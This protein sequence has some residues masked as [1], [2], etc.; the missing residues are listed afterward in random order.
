M[1]DDINGSTGLLLIEMEHSEDAIH[2]EWD[3]A[4]KYL[5]FVGAILIFIDL[6]QKVSLINKKGC[7][8]LGYEEEEI[9]GKNW[10]DSFIPEKGREGAKTVF[11]KLVTGETESVEY[12]EDATLTKSGEE[13][14]IS[15]HDTAVTDDSGNILGIFKS[16]EDITERSRA[17]EAIK[18]KEEKYRDVVENIK[19]GLYNMDLKGRVYFINPKIAEKIS[20]YEIDEIEGKSLN[21]LVP[22]EEASVAIKKL[23]KVLKGEVVHNYETKIKTKDGTVI[24]ILMSMTPKMKYGKVTGLFG[25]VNDISELKEAEKA[26]RESEKKYSAIVN[27]GSDGVII[28]KDLKV[29]FSNQKTLDLIGY[30]KI[31]DTR[32]LNLFKIVRHE[33]LLKAFDRY[34]R[35]MAGEEVPQTLEIE[36][37]H[38]D[39]H[40]IPA[41]LNSS[42]IE[43]NGGPADVI[44]LREITERKMADEKLKKTLKDLERSNRELEQ[45]AFVASHDLQ[46]PLRMVG[47]YVQLLS[48]RYSG[49]LGP[50]A[51]EFIEYAVDGATRMHNMINDLLTYSRVG[52]RGKTLEPTDC[53]TVLDNALLALLKIIEENN[54]VITHDP[55]PT[56]MADDDQLV[57][58]FQN[59]I[60]NAIRYRSE[61]PPSIHI[62]AEEKS[63][64]WLFSVR[65]NGIGIDPEYKDMIFQVFFRLRDREQYGTGMGLANCEKIVERHGGRMWVESKPGEGST[66]Y[67]TIPLK[68]V[69]N[70]E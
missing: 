8:I 13:R 1:M 47:S 65:D 12:F 67:F 42:K 39:G 29:V 6:N 68:G 60:D 38:K 11:Q 31:D 28:I 64:F 7:E 56:V 46:E 70:D 69:K 20:G 27:G 49:K 22:K 5:D 48:R 3:I 26:L 32:Q 51:D 16:G 23:Q 54:A 10:F 37:S 14:L 58:V 59:L 18:A 41:E 33:Y 40:V 55:L 63:D 30:P 66:F 17:E 36:L 21:K 52:R 43:Y 15:W 50:D 4:K 25:V 9:F 61:N 24:P 53:E 45:F 57:L 19:E 35:R 34:R 62:S 2:R 44:F